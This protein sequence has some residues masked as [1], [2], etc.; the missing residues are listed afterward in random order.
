MSDYIPK[1]DAEI[2]AIALDMIGNRIF[3][4]DQCKTSEGLGMVFLPIAMCDEVTR[5]DMIAKNYSFFYEDY[6]QALPRGINGMPMF[7][8]MKCLNID[9]HHRLRDVY[10]AMRLALDAV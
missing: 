8:S 2:K 3:T 6:S 10:N 1:T 5:A 4:S 9:D 7:M